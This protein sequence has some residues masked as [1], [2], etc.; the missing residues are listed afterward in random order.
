MVEFL[1]EAIG[2]VLETAID[3]IPDG[4]S[5]TKRTIS[6]GPMPVPRS[7]MEQRP[8]TGPYEER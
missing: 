8:P 6:D 3:L 7:E 4:K 2:A 5:K 1:V